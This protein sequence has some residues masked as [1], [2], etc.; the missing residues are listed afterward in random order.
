[1]QLNPKVV[2]D[3]FLDCLYTE[4]EYTGESVPGD[5]V[6]SKGITTNVGF[7]PGRLEKNKALILELLKELPEEFFKGKGD[8]CS[9][10]RMCVDKNEHQWGN[11]RNMEELVHLGQAIGVIVCCM[12]REF[13]RILP[14]GMPYYVVDIPA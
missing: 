1:M 4:E 6:L 13:W 10:L 9:F 14:G 7:N 11:H 8:G 3:I 2:T 12:G 5:A